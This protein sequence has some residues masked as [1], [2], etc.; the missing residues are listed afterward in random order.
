MTDLEDL[1][2]A[3]GALHDLGPGY[4]EEIVGPLAER[5]AAEL[6]Q[7]KWQS[8]KA[9]TLDLRSA[10]LLTVAV[11]ALGETILV[12][13]L[14]YLLSHVPPDAVN[15]MEGLIGVLGALLAVIAFSTI[16]AIYYSRGATQR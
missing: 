5:V 15:G 3:G 1:R 12:G 13:M 8:T 6:A 16:L 10:L 9:A 14:G 11:L 2:A 4:S 7:R